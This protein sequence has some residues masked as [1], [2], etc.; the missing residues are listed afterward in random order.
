KRSGVASPEYELTLQQLTALH[1][2][3]GAT[4]RA[5]APMA[6]LCAIRRRAGDQ[7][8]EFGSFLRSLGAF[9]STAGDRAG[10][11]PVLEE[12]AAVFERLRES[13]PSEYA[14]ALEVLGGASIAA[15]DFPR[16]A[17]AFVKLRDFLRTRPGGPGG[18]PLARAQNTLGSVYQQL[19]DHAR[20]EAE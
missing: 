18:E 15:G 4:D 3:A 14:E 7:G 19:G 1:L 13:Q 10:A 20:A 2:A 16:A 12:S 8:A 17:S 5:V 11:L 9:R 6:E